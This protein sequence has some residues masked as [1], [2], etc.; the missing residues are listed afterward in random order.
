[1]NPLVCFSAPAST[2]A[3]QGEQGA[4]RF[5]TQRRRYSTTRVHGL[6]P[7]RTRVETLSQSTLSEHSIHKGALLQNP[8]PAWA[9]GVHK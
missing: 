1:M 6:W 5:K 9:Y 2:L 4:C 3:L 7:S 8:R